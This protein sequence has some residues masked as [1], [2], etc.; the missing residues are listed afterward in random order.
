MGMPRTSQNRPKGVRRDVH[1]RIAFTGPAAGPILTR[2]RDDLE[3]RLRAEQAGSAIRKTAGRGYLD[4]YVVTAETERTTGI[5]WKHVNE[6]GL[7]SRTTIHVE[8]IDPR[9]AHEG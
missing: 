5:A 4:I 8:V 1:I 7:G 2:K 9:R 3:E 6:L